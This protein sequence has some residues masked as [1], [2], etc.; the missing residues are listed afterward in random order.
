MTTSLVDEAVALQRL[1]FPPPFPEDLLWKSEH[2]RHH[3]EVFPEG[4]F[5]AVRHGSVIGSCSNVILN[6]GNW[7]NPST[8]DEMAGGAYI[9][10]HDPVGSI[11]FG[12]DISVHPEWRGRGVG[13]AL[14]GA[15]Y[16]LVHR[17]RLVRYGT[18]C[19]IP[20]YKSS[21]RNEPMTPTQYVK[22]VIRNEA[23][24]RTLTPLLRFGLT[25][26]SVQ[27]E[28]MEDDESGNAAVLL[29]WVNR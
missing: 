8:W 14:Y 15:R 11:L 3:L 23:I 7:S 17:K 26:V 20:D 13:R 6:S 27:E 1:A 12:L 25:F 2:L 28:F 9:Q 29:E 16:G 19:R 22:K 24:D 18:A 4:Q 21:T 10:N 5:I